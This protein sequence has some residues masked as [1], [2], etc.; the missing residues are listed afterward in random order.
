MTRLLTGDIGTAAGIVAGYYL[1]GLVA[2][3][4]ANAEGVALIAPQ[5]GVGL[6]ALL[7][8]GLRFFPAVAA[9]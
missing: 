8:F 2:A 3:Q 9:R 5:A 6:A 7:L 1:L 4:L